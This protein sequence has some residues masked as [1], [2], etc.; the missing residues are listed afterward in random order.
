MTFLFCPCCCWPVV[1]PVTAVYTFCI[2][3]GCLY[4]LNFCQALITCKVEVKSKGLCNLQVQPSVGLYFY[5]RIFNI[6]QVLICSV[7]LFNIASCYFIWEYIVFKVFFGYC[8]S[9]FLLNF[10]VSLAEVLHAHYHSSN[11]EPHKSWKPSVW[12]LGRWGWAVVD[13]L[14]G[15]S[16]E[17]S[18]N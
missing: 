2:L 7:L 13:S 17:K 5:Y 14:V 9:V 15:F 4:I 18:V 11:I 12:W 3:S 8:H 6:Q 16:I 10:I 1:G